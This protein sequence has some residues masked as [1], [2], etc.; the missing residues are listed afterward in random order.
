MDAVRKFLSRDMKS[1]TV[2]RSS[3]VVDEKSGRTS[4]PL[5]EPS[6]YRAGEEYRPNNECD[7]APQQPL[8]NSV[9]HD[10]IQTLNDSQGTTLAEEESTVVLSSTVVQ[11]LERELVRL[12]ESEKG[13]VQLGNYTKA[14]HQE[15]TQLS[16]DNA[17]LRSQILSMRRPQDP[18]HDDAY[19]SQRFTQLNETIKSWVASS[20]KTK[21]RD[22]DILDEE[23]TK[24]LQLLQKHAP[25]TFWIAGSV[26]TVF[27]DPR[28]RIALVRHLLAI[29][30][31]K[32]I[33]T[34]FC[35]GLGLDADSL[36]RQIVS[37]TMEKR[38]PIL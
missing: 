6:R 20:F 3:Q 21:Q 32:S 35:F 25:S 12:R 31:S 24:L 11:D 26:K 36:M 27:H 23:E 33:F 15:Y 2:R 9:Q 34:R 13:K 30:L 1:Q 8:P 5:N 7:A 10:S 19:Y 29:L 22:H 16:Q 38:M 4:P 18:I 37:S 14:L 17:H 28:R